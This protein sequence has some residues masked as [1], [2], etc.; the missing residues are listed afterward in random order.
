M[1]DRLHNENGHLFAV[2]FT[3]ALHKIQ[4]ERVVTQLSTPYQMDSNITVYR[5][6]E[7]LIAV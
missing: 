7:C 4:M 5:D 2:D 6:C 3:R 1:A